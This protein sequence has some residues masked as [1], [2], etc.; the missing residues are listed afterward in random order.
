LCWRRWRELA[1]SNLPLPSAPPAEIVLPGR[2]REKG[3]VKVENNR[4]GFP[5]LIGR[6][7]GAAG[8][9]SRCFFLA[10]FIFGLTGGYF[11]NPPSKTHPRN[12]ANPDVENHPPKPATVLVNAP[13]ADAS[14]CALW[15]SAW[16]INSQSSSSKGN[17]M[18]VEWG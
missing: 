3:S 12:L 13:F 14:C 7:Q 1:R 5:K 10:L 6:L 16:Q 18:F 15:E 11:T 4:G 17:W 8:P 2:N 9:A